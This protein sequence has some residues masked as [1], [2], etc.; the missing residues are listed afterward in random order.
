M[1]DVIREAALFGLGVLVGST[2][3]TLFRAWQQALRARR[4]AAQPDR[5]GQG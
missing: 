3:T 2:A 1:S 5:D 4:T